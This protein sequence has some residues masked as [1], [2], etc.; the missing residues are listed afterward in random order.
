MQQKTFSTLTELPGIADWLIELGKGFDIWLFHG[1][2]GL[3][4]TTLIKV[5]CAQLGVE[6][7]VSS[8]TYAIV[9]EYV[10]KTAQTVYHFDFYRIKSEEEAYDIGAEEYI[11]SGNLCLIEW[12]SK[13]PS[14]IPSKYLEIKLSLGDDTTQRVIEGTSVGCN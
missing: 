9:N 3:G 10:T 11:D 8:P 5:I 2:M 12:P 7:E 13:I 4:K 14:L 6:D 1:D